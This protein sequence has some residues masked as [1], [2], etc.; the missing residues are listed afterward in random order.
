[1]I[2]TV[3]IINKSDGVTIGRII[4]ANGVKISRAELRLSYDP[5]PKSLAVGYF[6]DKEGKLP[7]KIPFKVKKSFE[8]FVEF[9]NADKL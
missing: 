4:A 8:I 2:Y 6:L 9:I 1:M 3:T 5:P 7:L